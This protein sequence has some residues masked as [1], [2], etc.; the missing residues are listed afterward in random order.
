M[1]VAALWTGGKD[2]A[3]ACYKVM[4]KHD[5]EYLVTYIWD[6]RS[7]AHP[8][9]IMK[10][11]SEA[12]G[13]PFQWSKLR[14]PYDKSYREDILVL[15]NE[16]GIEAVV[17]GD[18]SYV[19]AYHGNWIDE[20]CK[21]TG[22]QVLKPL[23]ELDRQ[24]ILD[25]L[26]SNGFKAIF[27]CVKEPWMTESWLGRTLDEH[28]VKEMQ[29]IH[30]TTG[31]DLCGENGEYHTMVLDAPYFAETLTIPGFT[32]EKTSN[33]YVMEPICVSLEPKRHLPNLNM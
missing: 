11:Q 26:L 1:K 2:S 9:S 31:L 29:E 27:S 32:K 4:Q 22:V 21:G 20:V 23:W 28:S 25:E 10:A 5:V 17:T 30:R 13:I 18:I 19:D 24:S 16:Y 33:G 14:P 6:I 12:V 7:R 15:K 8:F 3:L